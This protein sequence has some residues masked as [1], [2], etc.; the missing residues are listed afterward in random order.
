MKIL[1]LIPAR[2]GSKG[3]PKKNIKEIAGIPLIGYTIKAA[4]EVADSID[5]CVS[6]DSE[7][8]A[9]VAKSFGVEIPFLRPAEISSDFATNEQVIMHALNF[10]RDRG[11]TYDFVVV[12]QP[13]SPLRTGT[14]IQEALTLIKE[15][16]ELI[17]SVKE[18]DSNPYYVLFE[19]DKKGVLCK[20]KTGVFTRRQECPIVYEL[21]G[22]IYVINAARIRE[23]GYQKLNMSKYLMDKRNSIDIDDLIDFSLA[24]ILLSQKPDAQNN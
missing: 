24:E 13:T 5:I 6:T 23:K 22:A 10:Y 7:E 4:K 16:S 8:I 14:H 17:V 21:N 9:E 20:V 18:T 19:E 3:I 11:V 15:D 2:G 12:L 1:Y